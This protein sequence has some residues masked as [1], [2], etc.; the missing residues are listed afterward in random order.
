LTEARGSELFLALPVRLRQGYP[1]APVIR[2]IPEGYRIHDGK[3]TQP[4]LAGL[5]GRVRL[6]VLPPY[7]PEEN[8][9]ER[10]W[11]SPAVVGV[12]DVKS[13]APVPSGG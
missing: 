10:A 8:K 2:V 4:E 1:R 5:G 13:V 7:S 9:V 6:H 12:V 11:G 3:I